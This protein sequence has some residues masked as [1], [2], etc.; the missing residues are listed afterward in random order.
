MENQS[1]K[2]P[3]EAREEPPDE[4]F[5]TL[6]ETTPVPMEANRPV[7][8]TASLGVALWE[9][10][11]MAGPVNL[12]RLADRAMYQ[13]KAAGRNRTMVADGNSARAA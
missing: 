7:I 8:I 3:H 1:G 11:S 9:T 12:I 5:R 10:E 2:C 13:A 4:R 6:L